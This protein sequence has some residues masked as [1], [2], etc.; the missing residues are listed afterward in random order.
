M[1]ESERIVGAAIAGRRRDDVVLATKCFFPAGPMSTNTVGHGDGSGGPPKRPCNAF[2]PSTSTSSTS[3]GSIRIRTLTNLSW[4]SRIWSVRE[5]SSTWEPLAQVVHSSSS[6]NGPAPEQRCTTTGGGAGA[7][8]PARPC[9]GRR[10]AADVQPAQHRRDR[11]RPAQWGMAGGQDRRDAPPPSESPRR[12][13]VLLPHVV[14]PVPA[15]GR[16]E[17]RRRRRAQV[18]RR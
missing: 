5:K 11:L 4:L 9:V 13:R 7:L 15:G 6:A 10:C 14:G 12:A 1:G 18:D 2:K 17:V 16:S 3:I 8:L